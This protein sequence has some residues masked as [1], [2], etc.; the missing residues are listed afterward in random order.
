MDKETNLLDDIYVAVNEISDGRLVVQPG[1]DSDSES[2]AQELLTQNS[3]SASEDPDE[4]L[5]NPKKKDGRW[6]YILCRPNGQC[7]LF[8]GILLAA[9][10]FFIL[11][12]IF[13]P[14]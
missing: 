6:G 9:I 10:A 8:Y 11:F 3:N 5:R 7:T 13:V 1:G 12:I 2:D 14:K 4:E